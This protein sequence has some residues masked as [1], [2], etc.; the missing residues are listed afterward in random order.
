MAFRPL[1]GF[2]GLLDSVMPPSDPGGLL[3]PADARAAGE[4]ARAILASQLLQAAGPQRMPVSFGQAI[5]TAL[6][7]AIAF[8]N[9][10]QTDALRNEMAREQIRALHANLETQRRQQEAQSMLSELALNLGQPAASAEVAVPTL[11]ADGAPIATPPV[12]GFLPPEVSRLA[13]LLAQAG[14][15]SGSATMLREGLMRGN[16]PSASPFGKLL[17]D[18][19]TAVA[20]GNAMRAR[21]LQTIINGELSKAQPE[22][23]E[24]I[25]FTELR[26]VRNDT[27]RNSDVFV[28]AQD[29]YQRLRAAAAK[30]SPAGDM[31]LVYSFMRLQD[32]GSRVT[33]QEFISA[34][35]AG[36]LPERI[37]AGF[38]RVFSGK[39]LENDMRSDFVSTAGRQ[40]STYRDQQ[41]HLIEDAEKFAERNG[42][43]VDDVVPEYLR[44]REIEESTFDVPDNSPGILGGAVRG[45][46]DLAAGA[47]GAF[48]RSAQPS[49][50]QSVSGVIQRGPVIDLGGGVTLEFLDE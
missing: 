28:Q 3:S 6:P 38:S 10:R 43:A 5:G 24:P 14:D 17:D 2:N 19:E 50:G 47:V 32:P 33:E 36:S 7:Q 34:G 25:T 31:A 11:G 21:G 9:E 44:P 39:L 20:S 26:G 18:Y 23:E 46:G 29:A 13:A 12:S 4:Q 40:F 35:R 45:A 16:E 27:I 1:Q 22:G 48:T 42:L 8:Q 41:Q 15:V 49:S 30:P 37:Q